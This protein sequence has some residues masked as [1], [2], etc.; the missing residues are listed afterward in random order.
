MISTRHNADMT[1]H[2]TREKNEGEQ[3]MIN[4]IFVHT[5]T[6]SFVIVAAMHTIISSELSVV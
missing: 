1:D 3:L 2:L 5:H 6:R 4:V